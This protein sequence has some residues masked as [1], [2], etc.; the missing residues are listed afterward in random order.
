MLVSAGIF[1][2]DR[3][4]EVVVVITDGQAHNAAVEVLIP[5]V[6]YGGHTVVGRVWPIEF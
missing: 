4:V 6:G 2:H 1:G 3:R 5:P